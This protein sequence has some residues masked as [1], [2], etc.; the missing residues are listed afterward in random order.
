MR[1]NYLQARSEIEAFLIR[2]GRRKL[3][4]PT[5]VELAKTDEG[6]VFAQTVFDKARPGYHPI[7]TGSV[8]EVLAVEKAPTP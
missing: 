4:M 3:I 7:T 8:S 5:Y 6:R 2:V 1:S